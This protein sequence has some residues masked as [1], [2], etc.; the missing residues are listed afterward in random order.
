MRKRIG[1]Y[2]LPITTGGGGEKSISVIAE[3]L[4]RNHDVSLIVGEPCTKSQ[5]ESY[6]AVD[7]SR[8]RLV[9]L[10]LPI[11]NTFRRW[12]M[13]V[14]VPS[15]ARARFGL[16]HTHLRRALERTYDRQIRP[17]GLDLLI[18]KQSWSI[19]LCPAPRGMY[20]CMFP[21]EM[22]GELRPDANRGLLRRA[23]AALGNRVAGMTDDVL[24]SYQVIAANS[25]Y[26]AE[27][28]ERFWHRK[29]TVVYSSCED[30]G[31][32]SPKEKFNPSC[33]PPGT[34][35]TP[36]QPG[37]C[38][39]AHGSVARTRLAPPLRRYAWIRSCGLTFSCGTDSRRRGLAH[40]VPSQREFRHATGPVSPGF[41]LLARHRLRLFAE[42]HPGKQEHFGMTVVEAMSAGAVPVALNSGGPRETVQHEVSGILWNSLPE[43]QRYTEL[44]ASDPAL[45]RQ[46]GERAVASI[47]RFHRAAFEERIKSL[48]ESLLSR[49]P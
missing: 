17:L 42:L 34:R 9:L 32:L 18:N 6:F 29:A 8:V 21:H 44:L 43:L 4:S 49:N 10:H 3:R 2:T 12:S 11:L 28:I 25:S 37:R 15:A 46:I 19:L 13:S 1:V 7:L 26:T 16:M 41:H 24:N 30:M 5:L 40:R 36:G 31:P 22:K 33:W 27:W 48:A 39:S 45:L 23:Y 47:V 20:L 35:Q 14:S 38:L